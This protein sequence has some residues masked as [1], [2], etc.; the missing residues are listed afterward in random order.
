LLANVYLH[1]FDVLFH[2]NG[3]PASRYQAKLVRYA[4]DF[5]VLAK[6]AEPGIAEFLEST[7]TKWLNLEINRDKTRAVD[8]NSQRASLDFL[9]F[10]FRWDR[11]KFYGTG[12]R[13][14]NVFPSRRRSSGSGRNS[15]R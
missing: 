2:R 5:V 11:D 15:M 14:L 4:D 9:G 3:G 12:R 6:R 1:W 8:L 10:T 13:Y 7:L